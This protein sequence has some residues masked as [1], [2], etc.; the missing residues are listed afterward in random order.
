MCVFFLIGV[1][2]SF[3]G[4][5]IEK[6]W[7]IRLT[8]PQLNLFYEVID[9]TNASHLKA[10]ECIQILVDQAKPQVDTLKK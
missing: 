2:I 6:V 3:I 1:S 7:T 10:K 9:N 8:T 5:K 4:D